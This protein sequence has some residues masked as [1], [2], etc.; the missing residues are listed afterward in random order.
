MMIHNL[1]VRHMLLTALILTSAVLAACSPRQTAQAQDEQADIYAAVIR[2][3]VTEDDTF[4]GELHPG[5]V[6]IVRATDDKAGD[7][8]GEAG[9]SVMLSQDLVDAITTQ[10]SDLEPE[11]VWVDSRDDVELEELTLAVPDHGAI[12]TVGN[13]HPQSD[14]TVQLAGSIYVASLAAGGQT[15]ILEQ[16]DGAWTITGTTG[17]V[18]IS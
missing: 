9:A 15:Y 13:I 8:M 6:Y 14:G 5:V 18:W 4:G 10:L 12:V 1:K 16:V 7:P 11:I 3:I 2:R 17:V